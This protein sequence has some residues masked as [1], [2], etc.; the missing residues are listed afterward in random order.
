MSALDVAMLAGL[1]WPLPRGSDLLQQRASGVD[2]G[3]LD[4]FVRRDPCLADKMS[5]EVAR[6]HPNHVRQ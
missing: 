2:T 4:E 6:A 1:I 3:P 5:G